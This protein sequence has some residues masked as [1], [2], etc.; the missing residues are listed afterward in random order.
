MV[1]HLV[2]EIM[3]RV[4]EQRPDARL[5]IVGKDPPREIEELA[6]RYAIALTSPAPSPISVPICSG[7]RWQLYPSSMAP[8][9][10]TRCW[11]R[12]P[13]RRRLSPMLLRSAPSRPAPGTDVA[14]AQDADEFAAQILC[15]LE[16]PERR[17]QIGWYGRPTWRAITIGT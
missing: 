8:V 14:L 5:L 6:E 1:Q 7:Q 10:K 11:R 3:P 16:E 9:C 2:N 12:W 13:V 15:L 17:Q 4:W